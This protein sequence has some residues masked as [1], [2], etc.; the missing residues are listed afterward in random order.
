M[1]YVSH[2]HSL[3]SLLTEIIEFVLPRAYSHVP[4]PWES[5]HTIADGVTSS[6]DL[7]SISTQHLYDIYDTIHEK[8]KQG[9]HGIDLNPTEDFLKALIDADSQT[10]DGN[11]DEIP[12][13]QK[14]TR[15]SL[16]SG[17][18]VDHPKGNDSEGNTKSQS[19]SGF[20][21]VYTVY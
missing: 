16:K 19:T 2:Y 11:I 9:K 18:D 21:A 4:V 5:L 3:Y 6:L 7:R 17:G 15:T 20:S 10:D 8:Q 12:D 1:G 14:V 13:P